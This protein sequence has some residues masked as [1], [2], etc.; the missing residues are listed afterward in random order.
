MNSLETAVYAL[1][2]SFVM[3]VIL[4][5]ILIPALHRLHFGQTIRDDGPESHL[6]KQG[7]PTMGGISFLLAF[8]VTSLLFVRGNADA[9]AVVLVTLGYG[10]IGFLD[11]FIKVAFKRSLGLRAYQKMSLPSICLYLVLQRVLLYFHLF[12]CFQNQTMNHFDLLYLTY[13]CW[14]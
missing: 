1:L 13:Q 11:D 3:S 8:V 10:L 9:M 12:L 2:I 7:T 4:C 5:P 6:Q 14:Y